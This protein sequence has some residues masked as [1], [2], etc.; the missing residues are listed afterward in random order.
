MRR[1]S[2]PDC[3]QLVAVTHTGNGVAH[4]R[5]VGIGAGQKH[6]VHGNFGDPVFCDR[7]A[8]RM[9]G[10]DECARA[11]M[12]IALWHRKFDAYTVLTLQNEPGAVFTWCR[13]TS[14]RADL[15]RHKRASLWSQTSS[16]SVV[17]SRHRR[18][19]TWCASGRV[20]KFTWATGVTPMGLNFEFVCRF[21]TQCTWPLRAAVRH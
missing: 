20:L 6:S 13:T 19:Q 8:R 15:R 21:R 18:W 3:A 10:A 2:S 12:E 16:I 5:G 7:R 17:T 11:R 4:G 9:T 1:G 14:E